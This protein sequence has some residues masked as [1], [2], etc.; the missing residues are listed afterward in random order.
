ML[1][2]LTMTTITITTP[3]TRFLMYSLALLV[4]AFW[5]QVDVYRDSG[6]QKVKRASSALTRQVCL[7]GCCGYNVQ[8][9]GGP[10]PRLW[11]KG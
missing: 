11:H 9:L 8:A 5:T 7:Q 6:L 3:S 1:R 10:A 2:E 4:Q